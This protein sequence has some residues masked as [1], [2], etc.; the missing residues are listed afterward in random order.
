MGFRDI[1]GNEELKRRLADMVDSGRT[2][3][4]IMLEE[5]SGYGALPLAIALVQYLSCHDRH[6]GDSCGE[7]SCC[8]RIAHLAHPDVHYV[9]PVNVTAKSGSERKPVSATFFPVWKGLVEK[10][11]YFTEEELNEAMGIE[12][13]V[14]VINVQ[15]AKEILNTMNMRSFEG[16]NRYMIVFLPE[17]MNTEAANKLL[18]MIE[19]P[20]PGSYFIFITQ[21][22]E[23]VIDTIRSRCLRIALQPVP[24]DSQPDSAE[25]LGWFQSILDGSQSGDLTGVLKTAETIAAAGREKQKRFCIFSE[26][27]LRKMMHESRQYPYDFYE[28]AYGI[29]DSARSS[30]ESNVNPKIV[31]CNMV[32]LLFVN[33]KRRKGN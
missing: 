11:P 21:A 29:L 30:V 28:T 13:K 17:R 27:Y 20:F 25:Y 9:F 22:P 32:N 24:I 14:G 6:D 18:K 23:K 1:K 5:K 33:I 2:G 3:H 4:A 16:G 8:R 10:N 15:E 19:E 31:F 26:E 7:C 12:D